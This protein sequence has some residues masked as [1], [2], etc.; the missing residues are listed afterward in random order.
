MNQNINNPR[1]NNFLAIQYGLVQYQH[2]E[3]QA[4]L[5]AIILNLR[6]REHI[7]RT[8]KQY[9]FSEITNLLVYEFVDTLY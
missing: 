4:S 7:E 3:S 6:R 1:Q 5:A 2:Q 9:F 8:L